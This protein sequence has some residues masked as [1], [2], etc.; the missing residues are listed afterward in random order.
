MRLGGWQK[1][2]LLDFPGRV[3]CLVFTQGC[4]FTCPYCHNPQLV[5]GQAGKGAP[6]P[7]TVLGTLHR[8]RALLQGVVIS[9]GEPTLHEDIGDFIR[10]VRALGLAVKLDSNG[11]RPAVLAALLDAGLLDHVALDVKS[12]PGNYPPTLCSGDA[13]AANA[14]LPQCLDMLRASGVAS[15][16]RV[17]CVAPFVTEAT[18]PALLARLPRNLP[19]FLQEGRLAGPVLDP[20]FIREKAHA[21]PR[22]SLHTLARDAANAGYDCRLR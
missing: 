15:E 17:T 22:T 21:L 13:T 8:R 16:L 18:F 1:T 2:T 7:E 9:G 5:H 4:N 12:V 14:A 11:S 3:A 20:A 6:T 10:E 19:I